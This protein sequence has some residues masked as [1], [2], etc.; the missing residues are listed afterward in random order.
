[1]HQTQNSDLHLSYI[2]SVKRDT[3]PSNAPTVRANVFNPVFDRDGRRVRGLWIRNGVY[4]SQLRLPGQVKQV[5]L[6][7][8]TSVPRSVREQ[9]V[10]KSKVARGEFP[11]PLE[12][13]LDPATN[14]PADSPTP[15]EASSAEAPF[16]DDANT[17][18]L[19][20]RNPLPPVRFLLSAG[21][22][23]RR[24]K[25]TRKSGICSASQTKQRGNT[26]TVDGAKVPPGRPTAEATA[27]EA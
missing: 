5:P 7:D 1:M 25:D 9:Q 13:A 12:T 15:E 10:L 6:H 11:A 16:G 8:A 4:P 2:C 17:V 19:P 27:T 18:V 23:L 24:S 14:P 3:T 20:K 22:Y 26:R 21:P